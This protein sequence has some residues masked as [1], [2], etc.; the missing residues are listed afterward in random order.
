MEISLFSLDTIG[1]QMNFIGKMKYMALAFL[2]FGVAPQAIAEYNSKE[3]FIVNWGI[4]PDQ[5]KIT[6]EV[7]ESVYT[8]EDGWVFDTSPSIGPSQAIVDNNEY[9]YFASY[10]FLQLKAFDSTG[11]LTL[12]YSKGG[13][14]YNPEYFGDYLRKIYIDSMS[15][16]YI[17]G[18][19]S[20]DYVC[21][22]DTNGN[23][24]AKLNPYGES[25]NISIN[26]IRFN[27]QDVLLFHMKD[28]TNYTYEN[29]SFRENGCM[30]WKAINGL[31]YAVN[32]PDTTGLVLKVLDSPLL[33]GTATLI[34]QNRITLENTFI[35]YTEFLG[36]DDKLSLYQYIKEYNPERKLIWVFDTDF[37][38][39]DEIVLSCQPNQ[40]NRYMRPYMRPSDGNIYEF[41]CLD[42]GLHVIRWSKK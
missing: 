16:I 26:D 32:S 35:W 6:P 15:N 21:V 27:S 1:G 19:P 20:Q 29:G 41:R 36:V 24:I 37:R 30:A 10:G 9:V 23:I 14:G 38:Q 13:N 11:S 3:L 39:T 40:Y 12:D 2:L 8:S 25:S 31:Y 5:L 28:G 33:N 22:I 42:D 4:G 34:S 17:V 7:R 18:G